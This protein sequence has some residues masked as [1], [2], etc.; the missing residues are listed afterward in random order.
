[1]YCEGREKAVSEVLL[2]AI[3]E[4]KHPVAK[5]INVVPKKKPH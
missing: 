3:A 5:F 4:N 2:L 1:M